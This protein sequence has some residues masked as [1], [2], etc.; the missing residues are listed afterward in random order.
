MRHT[1]YK[2]RRQF[3]IGRYI[4]DFVC[5]EKKF[6]IELDGGHHDE[7]AAQDLVRTRWLESQGYTVIRFWNTEIHFNLDG[8]KQQIYQHLN[9]PPQSS[10]TRGEEVL[11]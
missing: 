4:V 3:L 9:P 2:F 6:I 5:P 7:Q 1:G 10:P 11:E 8:V